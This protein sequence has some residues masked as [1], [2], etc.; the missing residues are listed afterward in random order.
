MCT[1]TCV[2]IYIDIYLFM[3]EYE[4]MH[5]S[6]MLFI[7]MLSVY[8]Y[9]LHT[10]YKHLRRTWGRSVACFQGPVTIGSPTPAG[11]QYKMRSGPC[12][13]QLNDATT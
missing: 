10:L 11:K 5:M 3:Y 9:T 1:Y 6:A 2:H 12:V 13:N 7:Y 4:S 8:L